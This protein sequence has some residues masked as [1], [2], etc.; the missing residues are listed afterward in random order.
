MHLPNLSIF[1]LIDS[2]NGNMIVK[3]YFRFENFHFRFQLMA[4]F[5]TGNISTTHNISQWLHIHIW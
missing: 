3:N 4:I 2:E 5:D 1:K